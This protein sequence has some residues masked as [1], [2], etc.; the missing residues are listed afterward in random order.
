MAVNRFLNPVF[1]KY[2]SQY[3]PVQLPYENIIQQVQGKQAQQDAVRAR[4]IQMQ[5]K[6]QGLN[7]VQT[8]FDPNYQ[9]QINDLSNAEAVINPLNQKLQ[10]LSTR[11]GDL[12]TGD[13]T[14]E[15]LQLQKEYA[16]AKNVLDINSKRSE[17]YN[18]LLEEK[19]KAKAT[20]HRGLFYQ[21]QIDKM[22]A[23]DTYIPGSTTY[24]DEVSRNK[25]VN[26]MLEHISP[27]T[28]QN[29]VST[30]GDWITDFNSYGVTPD[31]IMNALKPSIEQDKALQQD[32]QTELDW[33]ERIMREQGYNPDEIKVPV[34]S[35]DAKGN[36]IQKEVSWREAATQEIYNDLYSMGL[37]AAFQRYDTDIKANQFAVNKAQF[38]LTNPVA[39]GT[40]TGSGLT[41]TES[42]TNLWLS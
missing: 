13:V 33:K 4:A 18:K 26:T 20:D 31:H 28:I 7:A 41:Y 15:L 38:D 11:A 30:A 9:Y 25:N 6:P 34:Y 8:H 42:A 19:A 16:K 32:I 1:N 29:W 17:A 39:F 2:E 14:A 35:K 40:T 24:Y 27:S 10:E 23:D 36:I 5:L 3:I 37:K 22:R 12:T 21:Q